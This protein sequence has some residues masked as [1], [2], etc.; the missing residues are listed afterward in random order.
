[1]SEENVKIVRSYFDAYNGGVL[2][3]TL[4]LLA[5]EFEFRPS[6]LFMDT[7]GVYRGREGWT[8]FWHTFHAAW[9]SITVSVERTEDLGEQVLVLGTFHGRGRESGVEVTRQVA[10]LTTLRDGLLTQTRSFTSWAEGLE[11]TGLAE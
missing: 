11:A 1:M 5:P 2:E 4:D 9:E 6:G 3:A 10:W 8:D 7:E